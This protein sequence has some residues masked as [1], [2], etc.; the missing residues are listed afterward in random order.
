MRTHKN[1]LHRNTD[2][3]TYMDS[4]VESAIFFDTVT[5]KLVWSVFVLRGIEARL[6]APPRDF[7]LGAI[8]PPNRSALNCMCNRKVVIER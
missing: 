1:S 4:G 7:T 2:I 3:P 8:L 6:P 5:P